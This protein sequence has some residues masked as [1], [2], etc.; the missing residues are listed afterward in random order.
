MLAYAGGD[1]AALAELYRRF[2]DGLYR[3][4]LRCTDSPDQAADCLQDVFVSLARQRASY[5]ASG[6]FRHWLFRIA[7]NRAVTL[8]RR[9]RPED[10]L[11]SVESRLPAS[12]DDPA[13]LAES[14]DQT[15]LLWVAL[16]QLSEEQRQVVLLRWEGELPL[17]QIA[18]I[19]GIGYEA[20]KSRYRYAIAKLKS[21]LAHE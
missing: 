9:H 11:E 17:E 1:A 16:R 19:Q 5:R 15:R 7:H 21:V 20:A 10:S 8:I 6:V 18:A 4:F 12:P 13:A 2:S 14:A 3:Y